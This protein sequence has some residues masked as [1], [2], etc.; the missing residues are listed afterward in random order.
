[1]SNLLN[2]EIELI[3]EN[4]QLLDKEF[5]WEDPMVKLL[6]SVIH[7]IKLKRV[8][9]KN[10]RSLKN[11]INKNS[12]FLSSV[13]GI[14][15]LLLAS[16]VSSEEKGV[17]EVLYILKIYNKL[18][19]SGIKDNAY[20]PTA[21]YILGSVNKNVSIENKM[22]K[23]KSLYSNTYKLKGLDSVILSEL[24]VCNKESNEIIL[25]INNNIEG[26]KKLC[27]EDEKFIIRLSSILSLWKSN[28]NLLCTNVINLYKEANN[29][30]F[31]YIV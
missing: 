19:K 4:Y 13:R 28:E 5:S 16:S 10:I 27:N 1:M 24:A 31:L 29:K 15:S 23:F 17:D 12:N 22:D 3:I 25:D 18:K 20:L 2:A 8:N 21:S 11:F 14:N 30:M 9:C 7:S 26:L 6:M